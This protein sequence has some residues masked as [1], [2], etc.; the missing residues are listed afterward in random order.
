[1]KTLFDTLL[2]RCV[3]EGASDLHLSAGVP[4]CLRL[5]GELH[6]TTGEEALS[7]ERLTA[8]MQAVLSAEHWQRLQAERG[9]DVAYTLPAGASST[10]GERFRMNVYFER[11]RVA[12]AVRRLNATIRS[13]QELHLPAS[14]HTLA[15]FRD[16]L[17][18][19]TGPTGSGKSTT[20]A[21]LIEEINRQRAC[22]ILTIEDPVEYVFQNRRALVHQRELGVDVRS[23]AD[24]V[25]AALR[26]DPDVIL[27]GEMRDLE[28]MRAA[29]TAAETGHLVFSTLHTGDAVGALDR[30]AGAF[31]AGEQ[32]Y[33][34]QQLSLTLRAVVT[35]HLL[36]AKGGR[37]R[38]PV[39]E[40]L[41]VTPAVAS[42]IRQNK[43]R[44]I[45]SMMETGTGLGMQT[46]EQGLAQHVADG[47]I[48]M[49]TARLL[50]REPEHLDR[51]LAL[52]R[53]GT[54]GTAACR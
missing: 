30:I 50:A 24:A 53:P 16:G 20:L 12:L 28:T 29:V 52:R 4:P 35:Q 48:E 6:A 51:L 54:E 23:F 37:G 25:R 47:L 27:V 38:V 39:L 36:P 46:L 18:L 41:I 34:R 14:L 26:E 43:P 5:R 8:M 45:L 9:L 33:V 19:V 15:E 17:V 1:M 2:T 42:L 21:T 7:A 40:I 10:T 22:H 49:E 3:A 11:G 31:P 13:A 44:Q 32:N